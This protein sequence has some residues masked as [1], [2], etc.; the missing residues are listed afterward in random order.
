VVM[1]VVVIE[2]FVETVVE[3]VVSEVELVV[4]RYFVSFRIPKYKE[5]FEVNELLGRLC[6]ITSGWLDK[7]ICGNLLDYPDTSQL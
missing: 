3:V 4:F 5:W 6:G 1:V 2:V 7:N